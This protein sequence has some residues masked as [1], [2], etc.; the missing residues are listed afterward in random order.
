M[1]TLTEIDADIRRLNR[2]THPCAGGRSAERTERT[3][4]AGDRW[5]QAI[6]NW[7]KERDAW[8]TANPTGEERYALLLEER[9]AT[10]SEMVRRQASRRDLGIPSR[11]TKALLALEVNDA[12]RGAK[13]WLTSEKHWLVLG[14]AVG[15]GK[16]VAAA[17][18]LE[19][20]PGR[21]AWVTSG[22]F[23]TL[24]GGFSGQTECDRLKHIDTLVVDD[25]GTEHLSS[26]AE[27]VFFEVLA[28]RHENELRTVITHNLDRKAFRQ[29]IGS[30][31]ADRIANDCVYVECAGVS[32]RGAA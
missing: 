1:R 11:V 25:F 4:R 9:D 5:Q 6:E 12:V 8:R 13:A 26:F 7:R 21:G 31:L 19:L 22:G 20:S 3:E 18:A 17:H 32:R 23:A 30:R 29:R 10:E 14:G 15:T 28:A 16:S 27:A 24:V 2:P